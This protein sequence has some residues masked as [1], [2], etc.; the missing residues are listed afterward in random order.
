MLFQKNVFVTAA[1]RYSAAGWVDGENGKLNQRRDVPSGSVPSSIPLGE[2]R[3]TP[4]WT[5]LP[6]VIV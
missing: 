4:A 6:R 3:S 2:T 5:L 1:G